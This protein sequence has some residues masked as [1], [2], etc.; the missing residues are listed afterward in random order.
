MASIST[1]LGEVKDS[2]LGLTLPHEHIFIDLSYYWTGEPRE[3]PRRAFFAQ[4]MSLELHAEAVYNPWAFKDN[5]IL[6]DEESAQYEVNTF[7]S[8]GGK[9][10]VDV[11]P[12][13]GMGRDPEA[14]RKIS[15]LTGVNIVMSA[16][17]YSEPS[18]VDEERGMGI[19]EVEEIILNEFENGAGNTGIKPGLLK[20]GFM[21][22][23]MRDKSEMISLRAAARAQKKIGCALNV[24]SNVWE[25]QALQFLDIIEEEGGNPQRVIF[26]HMDFTG[27]DAAYHDSLAKRGAY[28]EFDTFGCECVADFLD[29]TVWFK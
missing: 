7:K 26:S 14:L 22:D 21:G 8:W 18:M 17:R 23:L 9:T 11:T 19:D 20:V 13:A 10:I 1:V 28:I 16:G 15:A 29:P 3:V 27:E 5:T 12:Y 2:E 4:K 24:H 6:D 25:P